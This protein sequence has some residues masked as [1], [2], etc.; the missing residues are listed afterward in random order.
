MNFKNEQQNALS[1]KNLYND[2][3]IF[4]LKQTINQV[5]RR[6]SKYLNMSKQIP[7]S[8]KFCNLDEF[9]SNTIKLREKSKAISGQLKTL[10]RD[11]DILEYQG[12]KFAA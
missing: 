11:Q 4:V 8:V 6:L 12:S 5:E 2:R 10:I 3:F 7:E 1:I 9:Y